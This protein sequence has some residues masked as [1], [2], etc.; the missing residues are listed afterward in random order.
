LERQEI[1]EAGRWWARGDMLGRKFS[2]GF[3]RR[4]FGVRPEE[5]ESRNVQHLLAE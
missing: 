5:K 1:L 3:R 2:L 4:D